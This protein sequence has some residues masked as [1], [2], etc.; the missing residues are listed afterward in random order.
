V[1]ARPGGTVPA[2]G[3]VA[4]GESEVD[5]SLLTGESTPVAVGPGAPVV[6][7]GIVRGGALTVRITR[8]GD[9]TALAGVMRLVAEAQASRSGTQ[10]LAD[11]AAALLFY[12]ALGA[13]A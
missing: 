2:D 13:A 12:V 9:D 6:G 5:A 8:V 4:A 1:G 11:R 10:L 3:E 7:G